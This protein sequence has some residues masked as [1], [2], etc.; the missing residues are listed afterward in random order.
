MAKKKRKSD[1]GG[2]PEWV[3]T[4]GDL[5]SLLLT[6]FILLQMFSMPK[7]DIEYQRVVTAVREAFGYQG[8]IGVLPIDDPPLKSLVEVLETMA[9]RDNREQ[10]KISSNQ[11]PGV[12]GPDMRVTRI[13]DGMVFTIGGPTMFEPASAEIKPAAREQILELVPLLKGRRNKIEIVGHAARKYLP[14]DSEFRNLDE[15][16]FARAQNVR[17][18][19]AE[20]GIEDEVFRLK[21]VGTREPVRPRAVDETDAAENRR[22]DIILS[23]LVVEDL[24][25]D[26]SMTSADAARGG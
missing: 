1:G 24:D 13:R 22:V 23:E 7:Q 11:D 25:P 9:V 19:L 3:V 8:G 26:A 16:S 21:A 20:A 12:D 2:V 17:R 4:F 14:A 6:F 5:M 10:T 18:L 15:L